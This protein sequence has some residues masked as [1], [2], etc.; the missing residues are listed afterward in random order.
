MALIKQLLV[1]GIFM[2]TAPV[3]INNYP[4]IQV[5]WK[6]S[7]TGANGTNGANVWQSGK[8]GGPAFQ[9]VNQFVPGTWYWIQTKANVNLS[10][11]WD[12]PDFVVDSS[13]LSNAQQPAPIPSGVLAAAPASGGALEQ[14]VDPVPG[15]SGYTFQ[16][17]TNSAFTENVQTATQAGTTKT[18]EGLAAGTY[19]AHVKTSVPGKPDSPF[20]PT[21]QVMVLPIGLAAPANPQAVAQGPNTLSVAASSVSGA[22]SY[23]LFFSTTSG[24]T[25][26]QVG[27]TL[28]SPLYQHT[29]LQAGTSYFYKWQA[30][31]NGTTHVDSGQGA[32]FTG[33]TA[34]AVVTETSYPTDISFY[35][36]NKRDNQP[37]SP[38]AF[39]EIS[40]TT[41]AST[42]KV[43]LRSTYSVFLHLS[44]LGVLVNGVYQETL[45]ATHT[46]GR[47]TEFTV[48]APA[49]AV[50]T[51]RNGAQDSE[52]EGTFCDYIKSAAPVNYIAPT[53]PANRYVVL[54]DSI[55]V[56]EGAVPPI[57]RGWTMVFRR[58]LA[59][60]GSNSRV[61]VDAFGGTQ[62]LNQ[63]GTTS[64]QQAAY[65]ALVASMLDGTG[66]NT[67]IINLGRNDA[68]F[69]AWASA[70]DFGAAYGKFLTEIIAAKPSVTIGAVTPIYSSDPLAED[71]RA[72][73]RTAA[74]GKSNVTVVEGPEL[75]GQAGIGDGVHPS[76]AGHV[77]MGQ[78][79]YAYLSLSATP[80]DTFTESDPRIQTVGQ[81]DPDTA[82]GLYHNG[83]GR[84][85]TTPGAEWSLEFTGRRV[86]LFMPSFDQFGG[87]HEVMIDG[88]TQNVINTKTNDY[89]SQR[90]NFYVPA[91]THTLRVRRPD[92][93][94]TSELWI[95]DV[96]VYS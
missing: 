15:A 4:N 94:S 38:S 24:G 20:S 74:A 82:P 68:A 57:T 3:P 39:A 8:P 22:V 47:V 59:E 70:S 58:M 56:G 28:N 60:D 64:A 78:N 63:Y 73:I 9:P 76:D 7:G 79:M 27:G 13:L 18:W 10:T 51:I 26:A 96:F 12:F 66:T 30:V 25:F 29:G 67:L 90:Y 14:T 33:T 16:I 77:Q 43:G 52:W 36:D 81:F 95:D 61:T 55:A 2:G 32:E 54:G 83:T 69:G 62:F 65:V 6:T 88:V 11:G 1:M 19:Y 75:C 48:N 49:G 80:A 42:F 86:Q 35:Q 34:A 31:G 23:K 71:F 93:N 45:Q 21:Q 72:A 92:P 44:Q 41:N 84:F 89:R 85:S 50:I 5:A 46:D 91:G 53:A 40:F 17:A 37:H 87:L